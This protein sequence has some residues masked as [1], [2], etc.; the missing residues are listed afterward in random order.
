LAFL[1]GTYVREPIICAL[2]RTRVPSTIVGSYLIQ[3]VACP[4]PNP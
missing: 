2:R 3:N 4:S 1:P